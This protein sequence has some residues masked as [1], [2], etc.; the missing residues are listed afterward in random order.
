MDVQPEGHRTFTNS[1]YFRLGTP[2]DLQ[3][4]L[5]GQVRLYTFGQITYMDVVGKNHAV[6]FCRYY[7]PA[8]GAPDP[9]ELAF[10]DS[11]NDWE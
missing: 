2:N 8:P 7:Q 5:Q 10:C 9:L 6:H 11:F 4:L 3:L 1:S